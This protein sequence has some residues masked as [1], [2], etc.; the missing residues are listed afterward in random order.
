MR[1]L[2]GDTSRDIKAR[3]GFVNEPSHFL[4]HFECV[5]A[6]VRTNTSDQVLR[7]CAS[8][9]EYRQGLRNDSACNTSPPGMNRGNLATDTIRD[10]HRHA[11]RRANAASLTGIR[12]HNCV[13]RRGPNG[14]SRAVAVQDESER[15]MHLL[16]EVEIFGQNSQA[17]CG[18]PDV[19]CDVAWIVAN[20]VR[21]IE[22]RKGATGS[23][24]FTCEKRMPKARGVQERTR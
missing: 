3:R 16:G 24:P 12:P 2:T 11:V 4:G 20:G 8:V 13:R 22:T 1:P 10:Q 17:R 18:S 21:E 9:E 14:L 23:A 7:L 19:L 5:N 6:N 15:S